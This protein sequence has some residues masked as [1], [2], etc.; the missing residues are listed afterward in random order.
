MWK[1]ANV[2]ARKS[3]LK[4]LNGRVKYEI[5][6]GETIRTKIQCKKSPERKT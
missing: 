4:K 2:R 6:V 3:N 1:N 5:K